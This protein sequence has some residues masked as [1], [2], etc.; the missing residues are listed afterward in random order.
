MPRQ[1]HAS[2]ETAERDG[3]V[4]RLLHWFDDHGRHDL[5]WQHPR[6]PYRVWLSEIMLQQTQVATVIPYFQRFLQHFPTLPDLAAA[7]ND[8]VMAQWAGL[9]YYARAR[10]LHAAAKRCV[11][12]HDGDLPRDF[13]ALHALPGIGRSTAGAILSQAWNDPFAILDGNVKRVLSRYHGIDGFPG[14]PAIEKQLWSIA[15]AHVA[16]VP[17]GRMAD[18][19]QAQM[20]L[21]ATVCS[22]AKPACVICPLQDACV[23]RREGRTAELPTPKPSRT[24]PE[25]EAVALLLRDA[26]QR[27]LL[28]KRPDTG[29]WAQLW[30]LPQADAGSVLQD[31]FD[32]HVEGSLEDAEELP[33][34]QHTFSHYK[35]HL[36]V[37]SRQVHGL[38][39]EE[40]TLRWVANDELPALGLPAPIR[41]LLDGATIKAPKRNSKKPRN[42]E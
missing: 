11:E 35:L 3:F 7:S 18:Y 28:Q 32:A 20:D 42:H 27:V 36:Q 6:S 31:W 25:R 19:T 33:V 34:L 9:G 40:P 16:Q 17:A 23:A 41:K 12:L 22:R 1:P 14:L 21:G 37:L 39:V 10:N 4:A 29:I 26:Q 15:E 30:T 5:P 38:R 13:D 24:L 2:A 8:A